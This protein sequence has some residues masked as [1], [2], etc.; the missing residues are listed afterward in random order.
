[1]TTLTIRVR[2]LAICYLRDAAW[3]VIFVC[4]NVHPLTLTYP[5]GS[6]TA[7]VSLREQGRDLDLELRS[8]NLGPAKNPYAANIDRLFNMAAGHAHGRDKLKLMRRRKITDLAIMTVPVSLAGVSQTTDGYYFVQEQ[9]HPGMP[10]KIIDPVAKEVVFTVGIADKVTLSV[11]DPKDPKYTKSF[12]IEGGGSD[13][14][15][16]LDN[17]CDNKCTHN[18]FLDLYEVVIDGSESKERKF[19]A[20][21]VIGDIPNAMPRVIKPLGGTM[22]AEQGNCDPVQIDPPPPGQP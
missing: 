16:D 1:M 6:G 4:D 14:E 15:L 18:D 7:S 19:A 3:K 2:G 20:G 13:I 12:E 21:K 9:S 22:S 17:D 5:V 8:Q 11:T 10:V